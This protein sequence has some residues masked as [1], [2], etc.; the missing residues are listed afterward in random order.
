MINLQALKTY[1]AVI[2]C[3]VN[4]TTI[5]Y[6]VIS[7]PDTQYTTLL[8]HDSTGSLEDSGLD[9]SGKDESFEVVRM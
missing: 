4:L 5:T 6:T 8:S 3:W 9:T 1:L 2:V 7:S